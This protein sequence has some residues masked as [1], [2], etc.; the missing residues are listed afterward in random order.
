MEGLFSGKSENL[1]RIFD[2]PEQPKTRS[3]SYCDKCNRTIYDPGKAND[4]Y[5]ED[6]LQLHKHL[7]RLNNREM[8]QSEAI[9][10][11]LISKMQNKE[12]QYKSC[13]LPTNLHLVLS[14]AVNCGVYLGSQVQMAHVVLHIWRTPVIRSIIPQVNQAGQILRTPSVLVHGRGSISCA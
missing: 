2:L 13:Q 5:S 14:A 4:E 6:F 11:L 10:L 7:I 3:L 9:K 12:F 1:E 8:S